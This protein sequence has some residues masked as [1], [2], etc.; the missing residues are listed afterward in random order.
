MKRIAAGAP[1]DGIS[2]KRSRKV[3]IWN[4][5]ERNTDRVDRVKRRHAERIQSFCDRTE[6]VGKARGRETGD[7]VRYGYPATDS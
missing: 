1:N 7:G 4:T 2:Q 6:L 3:K 5:S